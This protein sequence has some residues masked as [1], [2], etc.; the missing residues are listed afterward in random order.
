MGFA[1][2][3][4]GTRVLMLVLVQ[5]AAEC[6]GDLSVSHTTAPVNGSLYTWLYATGVQ[7]CSP[8]ELTLGEWS[9]AAE[10]SYARLQNNMCGGRSGYRSQ[11]QYSI[12]CDCNCNGN[13]T[14]YPFVKKYGIRFCTHG[15]YTYV[16]HNKTS[17]L[18]W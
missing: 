10:P 15:M 4:A 3:R 5:A 8:Y 11:K 13:G 12:S 7:L 1:N 17:I 14:Q 18:T 16:C 6:V 9:G 2:V